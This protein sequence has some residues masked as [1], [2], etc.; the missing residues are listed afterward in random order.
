MFFPFYFLFFIHEHIFKH[1]Y[2]YI[3]MLQESPR[4]KDNNMKTYEDN[5]GPLIR[6]HLL[7]SLV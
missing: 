5:T 4:S 2:R 6:Q 3:D 7:F 1:V